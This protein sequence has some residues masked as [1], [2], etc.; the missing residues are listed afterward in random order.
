MRVSDRQRYDV[1][2]SRIEKAKDSS[3]RVMDQ[4]SSQRRI[5]ALHD[6]PIG[7]TKI[8]KQKDR[9]SD[10]KNF[11][12]NIAFSQGFVS[13]SEEAL[14]VISDRLQ[15]ARELSIAMANDTYGP[16]SRSV[17]AKEIREII[18]G[19]VQMA[20]S[21]YGSRFVFSGFRTDAPSLDDDGTYLGDDGEI[22]VQVGEGRFQRINTPGRTLFGGGID[23]GGREHSNLIDTLL[24]LE[25][26]LEA[27]SKD[28]I[29]KSLS[30]LDFHIDK[31]I[32]LRTAI[33]ATSSSL[34]EIYK[35]LDANMDLEKQALSKIED[36]DVLQ[37]S[38]DFKRTE[39]VLQ[40]TLLASNR[41]LQPSLLNYLQ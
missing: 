30:E 18:N 11:Q 9:L 7:S 23:R 16:E 5:G 27:N 36:L 29:H 41:L 10:L 26:G 34:N 8:L 32:S 1:A 6:D 33:G 28:I 38:S 25:R 37:A 4:L 2:N 13:T 20:N 40:S 35:Q 14:S 21:R 19:V 15:R 39:Q 31:T 3:V 22:F 24:G 17:T 12:T